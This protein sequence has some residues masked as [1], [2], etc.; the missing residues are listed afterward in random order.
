MG[1]IYTLSFPDGMKYVG[2]A[3]KF[4][5]RM[6]EHER[7]CRTGKR[8]REWVSFYGWDRVEQE[9]IASVPDEDL[10]GAER[11]AIRNLQT[12]W[13]AGLNLTLGGDGGCG[14]GIDAERDRKLRE[15]WKNSTK[16]ESVAKS[17]KRLKELSKLPDIEFHAKMAALRRR[18]E[19]R[20][21][22]QDKLE[23][24]YPNTFSLP[25]IRKLQGKKYG[26]P[27]PK[28]SGRLTAEEIKAKKKARKS[29]WDA[30]HK[31]TSSKSRP[32]AACAPQE[33]DESM[34][35]S[36]FEEGEKPGGS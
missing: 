13:P 29:A 33:V 21:M 6:K 30:K 23:R 1:V 35:P 34:I 4:K 16:P 7:G 15:E 36:D 31:R 5:R 25:Q 11:A 10:N 32:S 9:I 28:K 22:T 26:V 2:K 18:A 8:L 12:C 14:W 3:E 27:G 17:L 19:K 20:G 24:L